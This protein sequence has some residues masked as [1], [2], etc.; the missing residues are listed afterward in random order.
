MDLDVGCSMACESAS[1]Y[2][3]S[4][5]CSCSALNVGLSPSKKVSFI[6]FKKN[7]FK[8]YEKR[9]LFHVKSLSDCNWT[10]TQNHFVRTRTLNHLA[11]LTKWLSVCSRTRWFWVRIQ[12]QSLKL[13]ILRLLRTRSSLTFRQL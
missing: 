9:F 3:I 13:Q 7:P 4:M 2:L 5:F 1:I 6:C 11:N 8:N 12:Q 10:C